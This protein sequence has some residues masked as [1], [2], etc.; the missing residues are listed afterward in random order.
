MRTRRRRRSVRGAERLLTSTCDEAERE[1]V[2]L[3]GYLFGRPPGTEVVRAYVSDAA[4]RHIGGPVDAF[5]RTLLRIALRGEL[6]ARA[7]D[8]YARLARPNAWLRRKLVLLLALSEV[9]G[10]DHAPFHEPVSPGMLR[11]TLYAAGR[12]L[13]TLGSVVVLSPLFVALHLLRRGRSAS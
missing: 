12:G 2:R 3:G 6:F 1:A 10:S 11:F 13:I 4:V 8:M 5:D 7:A 9:H